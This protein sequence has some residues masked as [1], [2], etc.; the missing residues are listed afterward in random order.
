MVSIEGEKIDWFTSVNPADIGGVELWL[1]SV[2]DAMKQTLHRIAG[3]SLTAYAQRERAQWILQW[4]GQLVLNC[5]QVYWTK[6]VSEA[7]ETG[8]AKGL[9]AYGDKCTQQLTEVV[10]LVRGS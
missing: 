8:G 10:K 1:T 5:S 3:E 2:E 7:I 9:A 4:P 6:E